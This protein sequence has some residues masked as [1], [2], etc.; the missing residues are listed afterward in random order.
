MAPHCPGRGCCQAATTETR[1]HKS[2]SLSSRLVKALLIDPLPYTEV[3]TQLKVV[4]A[5]L[6]ATNDPYTCGVRI[7][8]T[9]KITF[10]NK[11]ARTTL[12]ILF[13]IALALALTGYASQGFSLFFYV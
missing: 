10:S 8:G 3:A 4:L 12:R 5:Y 2:T 9:M 7:V 1:V 6:Y 11:F 13:L